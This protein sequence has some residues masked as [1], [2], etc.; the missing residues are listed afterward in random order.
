VPEQAVDAGPGAL[1]GVPHA[2]QVEQRGERVGSGRAGSG[3]AGAGTDGDGHESS[4]LTL[5]G[6]ATNGAGSM[7][8]HARSLTGSSSLT[9]VGLATNGAGSMGELAR[10]LT[11]PP[12]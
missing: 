7:G 12:R 9:L 3:T 10:S 11:G 4:S 5:V 6:L 1:G 8:E 2:G